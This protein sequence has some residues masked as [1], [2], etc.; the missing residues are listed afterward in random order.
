MGVITTFAEVSRELLYLNQLLEQTGGE[1]AEDDS[2]DEIYVKISDYIAA[3]EN[4]K[5]AALE[6]KV[7][8]EYYEGQIQKQEEIISQLAR[9]KEVLSNKQKWFKDILKNGIMKFGEKTHTKLGLATYHL[10]TD[11]AKLKVSPSQAVELQ[12]DFTNPNNWDNNH[13]YLKFDVSIKNLN[14]LEYKLISKTLEKIEFDVNVKPIKTEI[15]KDLKQG[16]EIDDAELKTNYS[17][18]L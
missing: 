6:L 9:K 16:I 8:I 7:L 15:S 18:K 2:T 5:D 12:D 1:I 3:H 13:K 4:F 10:D 17:L 11:I 14:N